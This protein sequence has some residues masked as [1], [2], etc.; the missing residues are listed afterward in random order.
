MHAFWSASERTPL[1]NTQYTHSNKL[2]QP[3]FLCF[4]ILCMAINRINTVRTVL[5]LKM[6]NN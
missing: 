1:N 5:F 2:G 6:L 3:D 4:R